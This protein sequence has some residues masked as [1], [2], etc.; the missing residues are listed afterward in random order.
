MFA[1]GSPL[2][3]SLEEEPEV[4][5]IK[6]NKEARLFVGKRSVH[7]TEEEWR[8]NVTNSKTAQVIVMG[9]IIV[10]FGVMFVGETLHGIKNVITKPIFRKRSKNVGRSSDLC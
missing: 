7:K 8:T 1:I 3:R 6:R 4:T 10:S 9:G 5:E 2:G